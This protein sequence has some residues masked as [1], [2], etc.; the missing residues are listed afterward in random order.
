MVK[1]LILVISRTNSQQTIEH[2]QH[3]YNEQGVLV[4][5]LSSVSHTYFHNSDKAGCRRKDESMRECVRR[6]FNSGLNS[7][8]FPAVVCDLS[9]IEVETK[10]QYSYDEYRWV[11]IR[12]GR[13]DWIEPANL[14]EHEKEHKVIRF[15]TVPTF[16]E[17]YEQFRNIVL[18]ME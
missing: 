13:S 8:M 6:F 9:P 1:T 12:V 17:V 3:Y 18:T 10:D 2:I 4:P 14:D 5:N 15:D 7:T 11:F 16:Q